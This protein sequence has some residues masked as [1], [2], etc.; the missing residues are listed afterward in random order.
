MA[1]VARISFTAAQLE[2]P[3]IVVN[4][5]GDER[6]LPLTFNAEDLRIMGEHEEPAGALQAFYARYLGD[7]AG[8]LGDNVLMQISRVWQAERDKVSGP[9]LGE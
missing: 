7:I 8:D 2:R 5:D 6:R 1:E 4:L 9:A 3:F